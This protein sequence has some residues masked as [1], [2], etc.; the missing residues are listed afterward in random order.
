MMRI[1][2]FRCP[3][4]DSFRISQESAKPRAVPERTYLSAKNSGQHFLSSEKHTPKSSSGATPEGQ[5]GWNNPGRSPWQ[6]LASTQETDGHP[7]EVNLSGLERTGR[8]ASRGESAGFP[9]SLP[10]PPAG[11]AHWAR[12]SPAWLRGT[13]TARSS[14]SSG[15]RAGGWG[16]PRRS[17]WLWRDIA[18]RPQSPLR[19]AGPGSCRQKGS[20]AG[21]GAPGRGGSGVLL[22]FPLS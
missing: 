22:N 7:R 13:A 17:S 6:K 19:L 2:I 10:A 12:G 5:Q 1:N 8:H 18:R 11:A 4:A 16:S 20:R 14:R 21:S 15:S 3:L 9:G